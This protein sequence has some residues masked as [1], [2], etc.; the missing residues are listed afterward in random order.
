MSPSRSHSETRNGN[1]DVS[2]LA[3]FEFRPPHA[4]SQTETRQSRCFPE[5]NGRAPAP[6]KTRPAIASETRFEY[7]FNVSSRMLS[8]SQFIF[9]QL[10]RKWEIMSKGAVKA[11]FECKPKK[12]ARKHLEPQITGSLTYVKARRLATGGARVRGAGGVCAR[13]CISPLPLDEEILFLS[14]M[15]AIFRRL[16]RLRVFTGD[17]DHLLSW[18]ACSFAPKNAI[19]KNISNFFQFYV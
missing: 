17:A 1:P 8:D 9:P 5:I 3:L 19:K 10:T 7:G 15:L 16:L 14:K 18:L 11:A 4:R 12:S 2:P 13:E 6:L